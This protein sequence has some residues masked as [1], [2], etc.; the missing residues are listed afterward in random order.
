MHE[1]SLQAIVLIK[2]LT[3]TRRYIPYGFAHHRSFK[4]Q[5]A[6]MSGLLS[7][8]FSLF[9]RRSPQMI[10][11]ELNSLSTALPMMGFRSANLTR[12]QVSSQFRPSEDLRIYNE[13]FQG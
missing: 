12:G 4:A 8:H 1:D 5:A 6:S 11:T 13:L 2:Q 3:H 9:P 7:I 10:L